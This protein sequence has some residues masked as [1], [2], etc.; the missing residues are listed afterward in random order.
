MKKFFPLFVL[1]LFLQQ[2]FHVAQAATRTFH[3]ETMGTTWNV[4]IVTD[5]ELPDSPTVQKA[6]EE[7]LR[8]V[9][10]RMST[11]KDFSELSRINQTED[12]TEPIPLSPELDF[13]L[14]TALDVSAKTDGAYDIT[15][16]PLVNLWKFGPEENVPEIPSDAAIAKAREN[17]GWQNLQR[18]DGPALKRT[19]PGLYLDLSSIAKG[20]GVDV[21]AKALHDL[22]I[23]NYMVEVGGETRTC[24]KNGQGKPWVI[25]IEAPIPGVQQLFG[26]VEPQDGALATSGDYRNFRMEGDK[27]RSHIIDPRTG[28]PTEHSLVSVSVRASDCM[29]A[30]A[31]AT[32]LLVLGPVEGVQTAKREKISALFLTREGETLVPTAVDFTWR[33]IPTEKGAEGSSR[34][35]SRLTEIFI[36]VVLFLFFFFAIGMSQ[37]LGRRKMRCS[38]GAARAMEQERAQII[39]R[40]K[41][42]DEER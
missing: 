18:V 35:A 40:I 24:G 19:Q 25:G 32:A 30:D 6:I 14:K 34:V 29:T 26:T 3:G 41:N 5:A 39:R 36:G 27:R 8:Q 10:Y 17:V 9:D 21:T 1:F 11:W 42:L 37:L 2:T 33:R 16:G 22:G 20:Y 4:S 12:G 28:R 31:W 7:A 15:V 23:T 13:V 38:C